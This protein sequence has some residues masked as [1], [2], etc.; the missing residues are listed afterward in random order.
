M[1]SVVQ[2]FIAFFAA[3]K[4][5]LSPNQEGKI[6]KIVEP[7]KVWRVSHKA[8]FWFARS[9]RPAN[10]HPGDWVKVVGREGIVLFIEPM[11]SEE[12]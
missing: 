10:F 7:G 11:D 1:V 3:H 4:T 5:Q 2:A 12:V 9:H 6:D 8:T